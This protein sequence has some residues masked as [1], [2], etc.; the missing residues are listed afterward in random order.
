[1]KGGF[2]AMSKI[3]YHT[4]RLYP[5]T[6]LIRSNSTDDIACWLIDTD[7]N[8]ESFFVRHAYFTGADKPYEKLRCA[9]RAEIDEEPSHLYTPQGV[10]PST[11]RQPEKLR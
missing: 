9:L 11:R 4:W 6:V 2:S 3:A 10:A 8:E 5:T 7:Y 1:M